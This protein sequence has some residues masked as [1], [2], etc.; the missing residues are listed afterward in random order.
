MFSL[1]CYT[2]TH[3]S[4]R[5]EDTSGW[6]LTDKA[7]SW[8]GSPSDRGWRYL[9]QSLVRY[10]G[11]NNDCR[12][13]KSAL[14]TILSAGRLLLPPLWL[15][16]VLE[17]NILLFV[18]TLSYQIFQKYNPEYLIRVSLRYGNIVD[19][20][21]YTYALVVKVSI[22]WHIFYHLHFTEY[23]NIVR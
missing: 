12:Y 4:L 10:D 23:D 15:I 16:D 13:A 18:A 1:L 11:P 14:E 20:V 7:A 6:L 21:N 8:H 2:L 9:Q 5:Q 17:V 3:T 22:N 19:A